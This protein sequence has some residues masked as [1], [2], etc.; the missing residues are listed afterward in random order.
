VRENGEDWE[1]GTWSEIKFEASYEQDSTVFV[2]KCQVNKKIT[3]EGTTPQPP[4]YTKWGFPELLE[5]YE[6]NSAVS[7]ETWATFLKLTQ[8]KSDT[9]L[10]YDD[11]GKLYIDASFINTGALR[12]GGTVNGNG[13]IIDPIFSADFKE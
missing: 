7:G 2:Y 4:I 12:V 13:E 1:E 3:Y 11:Q 6:R 5:A 10:Y 8:N 9:G